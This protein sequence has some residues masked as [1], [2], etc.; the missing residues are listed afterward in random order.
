VEGAAR[1]AYGERGA[2]GAAAGEEGGPVDL[3]RAALD[4]MPSR[5]AGDRPVSE[6][7]SLQAALL[8]QI[9]ASVVVTD[10][11][12]EAISWNSG[13]EALYGWSAEEAVG[14][15]AREL[16]VPEDT[17]AAERL[18]V[19]LCRDGRWD[20]ELLVRRK[21]RSTFNAYV[22]NRL[23]LDEAGDPAA[24]V[25][26]A[27]DISERT[28]REEENRRDAATLACI[29]RVE[30]AIAEERFVLYAQPIANLQTGETVQHELLLR[31]REPDGRVVAPG[32]SCRWPSSTR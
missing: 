2:Q 30:A 31:M 20:G 11:S 9:D 8:D 21:D 18:L 29:D 4:A 5:V 14:R 7:T 15:N 12:G 27:V 26:V 19:E 1:A 24:V 23:A 10:M 32:S 13:A 22:R 28:R 3:W 6:Q 17:Q 25:G 16:I